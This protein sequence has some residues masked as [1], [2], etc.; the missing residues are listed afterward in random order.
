MMIMQDD[1]DVDEVDDDDDDE[2]DDDDNW[3]IECE[4]VNLVIWDCNGIL[5]CFFNV[6][7]LVS[8]SNGW[9]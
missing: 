5:F 3:M 8:C 1:N 6:Y 7:L 9:I 4:S 2:V